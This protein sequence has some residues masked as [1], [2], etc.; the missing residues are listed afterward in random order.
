MNTHD[1]DNLLADLP[2][3][4][5]DLRTA[6]L[7]EPVVAPEL[8]PD[9]Q[10]DIL[11]TRIPPVDVETVRPT[12]GRPYSGLG[13]VQRP[14]IT[15]TRPDALFARTGANSHVLVPIGRCPVLFRRKPADDQLV[16]TVVVPEGSAARLEHWG[17][18]ANHRPIY[19]E[20]GSYELAAKVGAVFGIC[21]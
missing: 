4:L 7:P 19:L 2:T 9:R 6:E 20:P 14:F 10:G 5:T 1:L 21:D 11:I 17:R 8:V 15:I 18:T 12:S 3:D 13:T 16:W